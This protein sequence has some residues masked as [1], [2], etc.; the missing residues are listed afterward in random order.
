[1]PQRIS[2]LLLLLVVCSA[3]AMPAQALAPEP[4]PEARKLHAA[5]GHWKYEGELKPGPLGPGG[6]YTGEMTCQMILGGFFLQC[7]VSGKEAGR[8]S[9]LLEIDG[10]GCQ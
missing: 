10:Y 5:V 8:E 4:G 2:V 1:M 9:R 7:Q 3:T 6:K